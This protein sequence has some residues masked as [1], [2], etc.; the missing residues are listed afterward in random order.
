MVKWFKRWGSNQGQKT[1]Q[2]LQHCILTIRSHHHLTPC[3]CVPALNA[4]HPATSF[5]EA[6]Y[7]RIV[8]S[9]CFLSLFEGIQPNNVGEVYMG[10]VLSAMSGQ[11]PARQAALVAGLPTTTPC[12]TINKVC[13][14]GMKAVMMASQAIATGC[15]VSLHS[16]HRI[17]VQKNSGWDP[18]QAKLTGFNHMYRNI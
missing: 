16:S 15:Q 17:Y 11:A 14:S 7:F 5:L 3:S 6:F 12:T 18:M 13:A 1:S 8:I 10:N 9:I 2:G 4:M